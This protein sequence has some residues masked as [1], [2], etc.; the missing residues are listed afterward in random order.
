MNHTAGVFLF[1]RTGSFVSIIDF[2]EDRRFAL[3]K[4]RRA[5][6]LRIPNCVFVPP[7]PAPPVVFSPVLAHA[8]PIPVHLATT[9]PAQIVVEAGDSLEAVLAASG[10]AAE[11]RAEA[12]LA[13]SGVYDL[14]DLR[15]AIASSG[16]HCLSTQRALRPSHCS[17]R[18]ES[19]SHLVLKHR[20]D[21]VAGNLHSKPVHAMKCSFSKERS[22]TH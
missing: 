3:P 1:G 17:C 12:A 22:T 20:R 14:A 21:R 13:L 11:N 5:L 18:T 7:C 9:V 10:I 2:H 19:R 4:I 8:D 6:F 15:P 16:R